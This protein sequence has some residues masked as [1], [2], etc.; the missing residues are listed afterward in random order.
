[1]PADSIQGYSKQTTG[2]ESGRPVITT[3]FGIAALS[4]LTGN[5]HGEATIGPVGE[6]YRLIRLL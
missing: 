5:D 6:A 1:M 2:R 3:Q 4:D